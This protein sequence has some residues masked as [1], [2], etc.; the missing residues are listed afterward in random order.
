MN[1]IAPIVTMPFLMTYTTINYAYFAMAMSYDMQKSKTEIKK[2]EKNDS[3]MNHEPE[4]LSNGYEQ[5]DGQIME[6]IVNYKNEDNTNGNSNRG[7]YSANKTHSKGEGTE[8]KDMNSIPEPEIELFNNGDSFQ[9]ISEM[10]GEKTSTD[11]KTVI[12]NGGEF[13]EVHLGP[14]QTTMMELFRG[15]S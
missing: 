13:S 11:C 3:D 12:P 10:S 6:E 8:L 14:C 5:L 1:A 7:T 4:V 9:I 15:N 2:D